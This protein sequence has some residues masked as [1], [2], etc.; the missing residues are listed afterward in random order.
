METF[1]QTI[2]PSTA[3]PLEKFEC[4][5]D[6]EL[7]SK[8]QAGHYAFQQWSQTPLSTRLALFSRLGEV[9]LSQKEVLARWVS[10]EM[11][12]P[13]PEAIGEVEK[14]AKT[15]Q[16]FAVQGATGLQDQQVQTEA[17]Q[18]Y[19]RFAP[20]GLILGIMPW[21]FPLWQV[22]RAAIP[23]V[24]VGNGFI[25][26]HAPQVSRCSL[27]IEKVFHLAGFPEGIF[28]SIIAPV[29]A[30]E[31][32]LSDSR[33]QGVTLTGSTRAGQ[34]VAALAG[35]YLKKSVLE[36]GG[37][38]PFIVLSDANLQEAVRVGVRSR[39]QNCGQTCIAA[40]RFIL[41][42]S[43]ASQFIEGFVSQV[44]NLKVG[45]PFESGVQ[46][47]PMARLDLRDQLA[48]QVSRAIQAGAKVLCGGQPLNRQGYFYEPTV[49]QVV[50]GESPAWREEL[51][52]PVAVVTVAQDREHALELANDS[53]YG[54]G[55][56]LWTQDL[57][58]A[59]DLIPRVQAG[60]VFIN[61]MTVS[62][63]RMP[64]GGIRQSGYGRELSHYGLHEFANIQGITIHR[65]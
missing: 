61:G 3:S 47:G 33:V 1:I 60:S 7:K 48:D 56:S 64:F 65:L 54:L 13:Y 19:V 24:L 49:L 44:R 53:D 36:L 9:L 55:C 30:T 32:I 59:R 38:D 2:N 41:E 17:Y 35:K 27:E 5:R 37:S 4:I 14:C 52:G 51:F 6:V 63:P 57:N 18:S 28:Q 26:K 42:K 15:C 20:L 12:K 62:D 21:N 29:E 39:F 22:F 43:I 8:L 45:D 16:Y 40:K 10:L 25:L 34:A 46:I 50:P 58:Q 31:S 11:G 23:A